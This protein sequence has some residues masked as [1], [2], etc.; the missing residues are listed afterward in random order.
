MSVF[1]GKIEQHMEHGMSEIKKVIVG[2]C[3][4]GHDSIKL[5]VCI[6]SVR[7]GELVGRE[8]KSLCMPSKVFH[9]AIATGL[10]GADG[11]IYKVGSAMFT[12]SDALV[13]DVIDTRS[14]DYPVSAVNRVLVHDAL[15]RLGMGGQPVALV[16][17]LPISDY[18]QG[19]EPNQ[20]LIERK[21]LNLL[22]A[23]GEISPHLNTQNLANIYDH[24]VA[25]EGIAAIYDLAIREDG[26]DDEDF[27]ELL[28]QAP[29]GVID[30]G[31]KTI[32]MAVVTMGNGRPLVDMKR[33]ASI[34]FGML[35]VQDALNAQLRKDFGLSQQLTPRA[36]AR[37][38]SEKRVMLSGEWHDATAS[39]QTVINSLWPEIESQITAKWGKGQDLVRVV[40][41]GGGA[42]SFFDCVKELYP[43]AIR[44]DKPE[45]ANARGML[46]LAM[47][48]VLEEPTAAA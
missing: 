22:S 6:L 19:A 34:N 12:V 45:S 47:L 28:E 32:D 9:G 24:S 17:G 37:L 11:G 18:F 21:K 4:D 29:V 33:S 36:M 30:I 1:V 8:H 42:Y 27:F 23:T 44:S 46:K 35:K 7:D 5:E 10:N 40:V 16:T 15:L 38:L 20:D 43:Q 2:G 14:L 48:K 26:S 39:I 41:A 25:S 13:G 3:D 31:G